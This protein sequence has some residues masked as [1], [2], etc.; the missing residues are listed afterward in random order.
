MV[1][2]VNAVVRM[3]VLTSA[4]SL[5]ASAALASVKAAA[6]REILKMDWRLVFNR[7]FI[8]WVPWVDSMHEMLFGAARLHNGMRGQFTGFTMPT[9]LPRAAFVMQQL[10]N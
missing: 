3:L 5:D 1:F 10:L 6:A 4:Q 7:V 2:V 9:A 8:A